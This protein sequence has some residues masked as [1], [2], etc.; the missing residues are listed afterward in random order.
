MRGS[1]LY[2]L[3]VAILAVCAAALVGV[4]LALLFIAKPTVG[5]PP[6]NRVV[7]VGGLQYE[8]MLGRPIYP[9]HAVDAAMVAGLPARD[10]RLRPGQMLF[11]AFI[12]VANDSPRSRPAARRIELRDDAGHVYRPLRLSTS[13]PYAYVPRPVPPKTRIPGVG[14]PADDN[15]AATGK[16]LLFRIPADRYDEAVLELVIHDARN[17]QQSADLVV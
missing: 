14:T 9:S 1:N 3:L 10:R 17:P 4:L 13:N 2:A 8:A 6:D 5:T 12:A 7:A 16:L 15:L 11:G